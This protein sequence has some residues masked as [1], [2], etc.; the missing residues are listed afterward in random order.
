MTL[1][2]FVTLVSNIGLALI[3]LRIALR[4]RRLEQEH[5]NAPP[6]GARGRH[7]KPSNS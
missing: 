7:P 2:D 1:A 5:R 4:Q 3:V 6:T